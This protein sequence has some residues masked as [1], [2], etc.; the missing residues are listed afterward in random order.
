MECSI[1]P[2][3]VEWT[4]T[5]SVDYCLWRLSATDSSGSSFPFVLHLSQGEIIESEISSIPRSELHV[6]GIKLRDLSRTCIR[7]FSFLNIS[8]VLRAF[9]NI[10][11]LK[12]I[13]SLPNFQT[14]SSH[15]V[16]FQ[17]PK[18][19]KSPNYFEFSYI[20]SHSSNGRVIYL[21]Y[22]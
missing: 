13:E 2:C 14:F 21:I 18:T 19:F 16:S 12:F 6:R 11:D 1:R 3:L 17:F 9:R 5:H 10:Q 4:H 20:F 22:Y 15:F 8:R 7:I